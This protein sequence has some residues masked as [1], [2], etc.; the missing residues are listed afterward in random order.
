MQS[1]NISESL[2]LSELFPKTKIFDPI[3]NKM[4]LLKTMKSGPP[5]RSSE[6]PKICKFGPGQPQAENRRFLIKV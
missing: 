6:N 4:V 5:R 2:N 1:I 3:E